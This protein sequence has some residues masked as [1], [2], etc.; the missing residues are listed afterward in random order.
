[1]LQTERLLLRPL[2]DDDAP[3]IIELLNE[4]AFI[5][6]IGDRKVR[7]IED[8]VRYIDNGPRA[9]LRKH[10]YGM[11]RVN[12]RD[13]GT[14]IG[15]CGLIR[16]ETLPDVDLG[17]AYLTQHHRKGY[18]VEAARAMLQQARS[19]HA[20]GRVLAITLPD[21]IGSIRVLQSVGFVAAGTVR[22]G[23][24]AELLNLYE[25]PAPTSHQA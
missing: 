11:L 1:M 7:T 19:E 18:A 22:I 16:R 25:S 6:N 9:S 24:D 2:T 12:L 23:D 8:A 14:P 4:P 3:F 13:S 17:F 5:R 20:I 10:G 21:N 15:L